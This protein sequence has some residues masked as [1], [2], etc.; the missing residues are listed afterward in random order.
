MR[1]TPRLLPVTLTLISLMATLVTPA[2]ASEGTAK[3]SIIIDDVGYSMELGRR[4]IELPGPITLA[5]IPFTPNAFALAQLA[6]R[7]GKDVILH[8]PMEAVERH[9]RFNTATTLT[10]EMSDDTFRHTLDAALDSLPN[11]VGV[12]NHTGSL[13]TQRREPMHRLMR[14]IRKRH[15]FFLDS[16]T[17]SA[18][19]AASVARETGVPTLQRDVFLD[20]H[21]EPEAIAAS[22]R[23]ALDV[24]RK[25][26]HA[27]IIAHPHEA[28]LAFLEHTLPNLNESEFEWVAA[29]TLVTTEEG[30]KPEQLALITSGEAR[31]EQQPPKL[32]E[33]AVT[34]VAVD[35][36]G[37]EP[38]P[39]EGSP[40]TEPAL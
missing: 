3:L 15:L 20:H 21:P 38:H 40:H 19:V 10:L 4:I 2:G 32:P 1:S 11:V 5:V 12:N 8:Q 14:Q 25:Q 30:L 37:P 31:A 39:V 33:L 26:G 29:R 17:T 13:L 34:Q 28:T 35:A 18:T 7:A 9:R 24:A 6:H 23:H 22:F 27:V 36:A 16:R